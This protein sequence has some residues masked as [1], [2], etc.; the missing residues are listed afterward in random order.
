MLVVV[1]KIL[2]G[3]NFNLDN[4]RKFEKLDGFFIIMYVFYYNIIDV[5]NEFIIFIEVVIVVINF[6]F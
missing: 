4:L 5:D 3:V 6:I 1:Y 2:D